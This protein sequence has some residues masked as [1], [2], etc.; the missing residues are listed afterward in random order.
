MTE[1]VARR[2][3]DGEIVEWVDV[4]ARARELGLEPHPEGGWY[5]RTWAAPLAVETPG[6]RRAAATMI[7]FFLPPGESSAW[8]VVDSDEIWLWHGP[9]SVRVQFGGNGDEPEAF[10]VHEIDERNPQVI[11]PGGT[12]QRTLPARHDAL[13]S[14]VVSPGFDFADFRLA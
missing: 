5:R 4:P 3:V 11:V 10:D 8:H 13:V 2:G 7:L 1:R 12:W 14:C 9:G 6:G